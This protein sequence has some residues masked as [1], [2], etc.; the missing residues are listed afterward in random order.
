MENRF[1]GFRGGGG[2]GVCNYKGVYDT[3]PLLW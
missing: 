3:V 1:L 2:W